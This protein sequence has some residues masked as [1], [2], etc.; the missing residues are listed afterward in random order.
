MEGTPPRHLFPHPA[1]DPNQGLSCVKECHRG[2]CAVCVHV[3]QHHQPIGGGYPPAIGLVAAIRAEETM[4]WFAV[5][6]GAALALGLACAGPGEE[7]PIR[8]IDD[9]ATTNPAEVTAQEVGADD[10]CVRYCEA[11]AGCGVVA[12][13]CVDGCAAMLEA[14][15]GRQQTACALEAEGCGDLMDCLEE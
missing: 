2:G 15:A 6:V 10:T 1:V 8:G 14:D 7:A 5:S 3:D 12:D 4:R 11:L 13:D 9:R